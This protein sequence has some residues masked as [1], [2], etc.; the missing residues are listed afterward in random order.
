VSIFTPAPSRLYPI[1]RLTGVQI[2]ATGAYVPENVVTNEQLRDTCGVDPDW[3]VQRTGI[4][5]RRHAPPDEATSDLAARAARQC[6][7]RAGV[8]PADVDL[9]IVGTF[10]PDLLCPSTAC[11]VQEK[12]GLRCG[13]FDVQAACA[14]FMYA[15]VTGMQFVAA[16]TSRRCLV[17][18]ADCNSRILNPKDGKIFPLFGDGAGAVLLTPGDSDQGFA[19]Y[20]LGS[21]GAGCDVLF[22][23]V[24]GSKRPF[25]PAEATTDEHFLLMDGKPVFKWAVRLVEDGIREI[26]AAA[27]LNP[28]QLKLFILHQAN[29]RIV[30]AIAEALSLDPS[31]L[32]K[33]MQRYGNTSAASIPLALDECLQTGKI[34][35]GD[36]ILMSGFGA[37]LAWGTGIWRW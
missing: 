5:E 9:L 18:G 17:I 37:G 30:N 23:P 3:I 22:R 1:R 28:D 12:L 7:E 25:S 20:S 4:R 14:G 27:D 32:A 8:S 11:L 19:A 6:L 33:Q 34:R 2:A 13:A 10:T 16:G 26:S 15:L 36:P 29:E 24:G 21:D 35:R 31:R